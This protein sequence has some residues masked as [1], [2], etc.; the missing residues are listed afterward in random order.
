MRSPGGY[1]WGDSPLHR[2]GA[3][4]KL[5]GLLGCSLAVALSGGA[6]LA[7][8]CLGVL[9]LAALSGVGWRRALRPVVGMRWFLLLV[10]AMNALLWSRDGAI[11]ALGPLALTAAGIFR[12]ASVAARVAAVAVLG[13]LLTATTQPQEIVGGVRALLRPLARL[14]VPTEAAALAVGV[15][16]QFVPTLLREGRQ[17]ARAQRVR[18]GAVASRGIMRRAVSYVSLLVPVFVAAFRRADELSVAMEARGY[19]VAPSR[20]RDVR[21]E[22]EGQK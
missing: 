9:A 11:L 13:S 1:V 21:R 4:A 7:L 15:T 8:C 19:E 14:G 2:M 12:G 17:L 3:A 18:C 5:A 20:G 10:L 6:A 16:V 22:R